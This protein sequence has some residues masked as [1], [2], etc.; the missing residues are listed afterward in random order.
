MGWYVLFILC[1]FLHAT[2]F[3]LLLNRIGNVG[4]AIAKGLKTGIYIFLA[5]FMYCS[6]IEKYCLFPLDRWQRD[7]TL[8]SA[9]M[10]IFGVISYGFATKKYNEKKARKAAEEAKCR[11][12][13]AATTG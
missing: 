5:H 4:T 12:E 2:C 6:N 10:S 1:N 11:D 3:F 9:L 13:E 8:A 7:I